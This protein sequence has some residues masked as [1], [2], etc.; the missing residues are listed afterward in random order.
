MTLQGNLAW[1]D[2][3]VFLRLLDPGGRVG[4]SAVVGMCGL[5]EKVDTAGDGNATVGST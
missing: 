4:V 5:A 2:S 3:I 1:A